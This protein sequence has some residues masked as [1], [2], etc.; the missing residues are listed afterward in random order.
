M[1]CNIDHAYST[2]NIGK[3]FCVDKQVKLRFYKQTPSALEVNLSQKV[4][5]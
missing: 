2:D 4:E 3:Q 5:Y 1:I